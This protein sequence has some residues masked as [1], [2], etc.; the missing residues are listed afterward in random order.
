MSEAVA[1]WDTFYVI[2]GSSAAALTGL[3]FVVI[4]LTADVRFAP[5]DRNNGLDAYAT[6][7]VMHF[8]LVLL[9][10]AV[11]TSPRQTDVTV[12]G[13]IAAVALI[14]L[15]YMV[16]VLLRMRRAHGYQPVAEDWIWHTILP[17]VAYISLAASSFFL[18]SG[19]DN[20]LY[21]VGAD[22]L[23]LLYVGIH[24]AW[25]TATWMAV[26]GNQPDQSNRPDAPPA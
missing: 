16:V 5:V 15:G 12:G 10:A 2:I 1:G 18:W 19:R 3:M 9:L 14:G 24:N 4:S 17:L 25:D 22:A 26:H 23:L 20:W 21:C 13:G 7:T 6:P 11:L 8:C